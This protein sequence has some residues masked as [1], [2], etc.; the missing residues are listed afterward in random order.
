MS[1]RPVRDWGNIAD[2]IQVLTLLLVPLFA[3]LLGTLLETWLGKSS[4]WTGVVATALALA[5]ALIVILGFSRIRSIPFRALL[6]ALGTRVLAESQP[7]F[8]T[9][10][11]LSAGVGTIVLLILYPVG[12]QTE[13]RRIAIG[14]TVVAWLVLGIA[15]SNARLRELRAEYSTLRDIAERL[16]NFETKVFSY[17]DCDHDSIWEYDFADFLD[18]HTEVLERSGPETCVE[19][20][21][22]RGIERESIFQHPPYGPDDETDAILRFSGQPSRATSYLVLTFYTGIRDLRKLP[23]GSAENSGFIPR[24][25]NRIRFQIFVNGHCVFQ[26]IRDS[27]E[28]RFHVLVLPPP[29]NQLYEVEF[30]T[31]ALGNSDWNWA[32]WGEPRL[33]EWSVV[34]KDLARLQ[35]GRD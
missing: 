30:R 35:E 26:E 22:C 27:F 19:V 11:L 2:W 25:G 29:A 21:S 4:P 16:T 33:A 17:P 5:C 18:I 32:V 1:N 15:S 9:R 20:A 28:W 3:A 14:T 7:G 12:I 8:L 23:D 10:L 31:N 24:A 13:N 34:F 6:P